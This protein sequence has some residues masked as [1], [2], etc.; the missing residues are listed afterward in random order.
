[1]INTAYHVV[2]ALS[3]GSANGYIGLFLPVAV[4]YKP[5]FDASTE[6]QFSFR[7]SVYV[8]TSGIL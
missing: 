5:T 1:M 6:V 3:L 4:L 2:L 7:L 8:V